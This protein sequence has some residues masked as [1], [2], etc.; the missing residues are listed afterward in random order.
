MK[1]NLRN[2]NTR[3]VVLS[4][5]CTASFA[6]A[7]QTQV[8]RGQRQRERIDE[9]RRDGSLTTHEQSKLNNHAQN[10]RNFAQGARADGVVNDAERAA[11]QEKRENQNVRI[12]EQRHDDQRAQGD[13]FRAERQES[14]IDRGVAQGDL[15]RREAQRLNNHMQDITDAHQAARA[16]GVVDDA[17]R[18]AIQ[19]MRDAQNQRI[20]QQRHDAQSDLTRLERQ[21]QRI[22]QG[23]ASGALNSNESARLNNRMQSIHDFRQGALADGTISPAERAAIQRLRDEQSRRINDQKHDAQREEQFVD[24]SVINAARAAETTAATHH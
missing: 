13:R 21:R 2:L 7:Q 3:L 20:V 19:Q 22:D 1:I 24:E 16:D 4:L 5:F 8:G 17:E 12:H 14:R 9:G 15:N 10:I 23:V 6:N 11:I 18:A